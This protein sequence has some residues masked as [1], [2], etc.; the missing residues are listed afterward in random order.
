MDT[1][2]VRS[3]DHSPE[4]RA[5]R[6]AAGE[7]SPLPRRNSAPRGDP[8]GAAGQ[9]SAAAPP[10][11]HG[12]GDALAAAEALLLFPPVPMEDM[13]RMSAWLAKLAGLV[14]YAHNLE[15]P[16]RSRTPARAQTPARGTVSTARTPVPGQAGPRVA[17]A[18]QQP[19]RDERRGDRQGEPRHDRQGDGHVSIGST[20]SP[21]GDLRDVL[22]D[23]QGEDAR[24]RIERRKERHQRDDRTVTHGAGCL[25]FVPELRKVK[26]P[27]KFRPDV[28]DRYDGQS[29]PAEFLQV[30]STAV[31]AA[32]GDEKVMANWFSLALKPNARSW[33]VNLPANS[34]K[35]WPDL[36][37]QFVGA[38][39]G[40]FRRP[41]A[42]SDLHSLAQKPDET[43]RKYT[44]RFCQVQHTIPDISQDAIIAAFHSNVRDPKM[45]EKMSTRAIRSTAELFQLADKCA[46]AEEGRQAPDAGATEEGDPGKKPAPKRDAKRVFSAEPEPK[47]LRAAGGQWCDIH[48]TAG[49]DLK[50]CRKVQFLADEQKKAW[51]AEGP[52]QGG[53]RGGCF[54]CGKPGH[55]VRD[56]PHRSGGGRGQGGRGGGRGGNPGGGRGGRGGRERPPRGRDNNNGGGDDQEAAGEEGAEEQY[57]EALDVVCIHGGASSFSSHG[58][59]KRLSREVNAVQPGPEAQRPLRWSAVPISFSAADHPDRTSGVGILPLVVSPTI[60]NTKVTK[61][62]VDGGAG[63]NLL[64]ARV[65]ARLQVPAGRLR[66]TGTFQGVNPG[67]TQPLGQIELPVTFG[68]ADNFRTENVVFDVSDT[69]LPYNGILG[70]PALSKF[71]AASHHAYNVLKMP[72]AWGVLAIK[73]DRQDAIFCVEQMWRAAAS[74]TPGNSDL[75]GPSEPSPARKKLLTGDEALTK[76]VPLSDDGSHL[77][78]IGSGLAAK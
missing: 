62:L 38:F 67:V 15:E 19:P 55:I 37:D 50:D 30:Y 68:T 66:P 2:L 29:N 20:L 32:G 17:A 43:L 4:R 8:A 6:R 63:I 1:E 26:W 23:R 78:T 70:R 27:H 24:T 48:G 73:A 76:Q 35:S 65:F 49:H 72:G 56:C 60:N 52:R 45:R 75:A 33:L 31:Q 54:H 53:A 14:G 74:V 69:P 41:G 59:F 25:A 5:A 42:V 77:V 39:Q 10:G 11:V 28:P 51:E 40:G 7:R 34:V 3:Q 58:E 47:K 57:P 9:Q 36:C 16:V 12:P 61:M 64:S 22:N 46:R 13:P 44:Q 71:M 18:Q 21:K